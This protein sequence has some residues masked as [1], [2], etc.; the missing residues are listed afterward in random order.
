MPRIDGLPVWAALLEEE[1]SA[2]DARLD[3]GNES[4]PLQEH[5]ERR[6]VDEVLASRAP[7]LSTAPPPFEDQKMLRDQAAASPDTWAATAGVASSQSENIPSRSWLAGAIITLWLGV[8]LGL[9][10]LSLV[11]S[12]LLTRRTACE[13][14][15]CRASALRSR[16]FDAETHR[17]A[18]TSRCGDDLHNEKPLCRGVVATDRRVA[19]FAGRA[20]NRAGA[21]PCFVAR[22]SA[23]STPRPGS[24]LGDARA[25][26]RLLVQSAGLAGAL[27]TARRLRTSVRPGRVEI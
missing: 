23:P 24:P 7:T 14:A 15:A 18:P 12:V 19:P 22:T 11:K 17:T 6:S 13:K 21:S 3:K 1:K 16:P 10:G 5:G 2:P 8:A 9:L 4:S 20:T 27:S 25:A 26:C